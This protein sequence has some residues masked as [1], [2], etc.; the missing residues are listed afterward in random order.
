MCTDGT[1]VLAWLSCRL[2][3]GCPVCFNVRIALFI[4]DE[5]ETTPASVRLVKKSSSKC[6]GYNLTL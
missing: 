3:W 6:P 2:C 1:G 5:F 4:F